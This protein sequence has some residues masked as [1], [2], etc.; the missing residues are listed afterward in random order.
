MT[1]TRREPLYRQIKSH[2]TAEI[3]RGRWGPGSRVP[4][5]NELVTKFGISRMTANRALRELM[6]EGYLD[7]RPGVGTFVRDPLRQTSLVELSNIA[8]EIAS[9]GGR[10]TA[11]V[12]ELRKVRADQSLADTFATT[13]AATLYYVSLVH[14]EDGT[15]V[16]LERRFV[17]PAAAPFFLRQDFSRLTPT[18]YLLSVSPVDELE[19]S[20]KAVVPEP[21]VRRLLVLKLG[22][23][24]LALH[25]RSWSRGIVVTDA[26]LIYPADRYELKSRYRTSPNGGL[27]YPVSADRRGD[28][29]G[30][31]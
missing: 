15:P 30:R 26:V 11:R 20:V 31:D 7:R 28:D 14:S 9:R 23:P 5:E 4:S 25:R 10:H 17:N 1:R 3:E 8:E 12:L 21:E 2:V 24:A 18:E 22:T 6:H 13:L 16:Q 27:W 19:H 29:N